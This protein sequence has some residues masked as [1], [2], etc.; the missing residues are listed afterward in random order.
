MPEIEESLW[1][2]DFKLPDEKVKTKKIKEK[3]SKPKTTE[4]SIEKQV[5]SKKVSIKEKMILIK[6]EVLRV[7]GKQAD[8]VMCIRDKETLND[9]ISKAIKVGRIAIDTETNNTTDTHTCKLMGPCLYTPGEKQV[10]IPINHRDPETKE[11]LPNQLTEQDMHDAFQRIVDAGTHIIMHHADFDYQVIHYT[12]GIDLPVFWDTMLAAQVLNENEP[13]SLKEQYIAKIDPDQ[14]KYKIN[15]LFEGV[16]YA[17]VDPDVFAF[18]AATD[19]K[20]TDALYEWQVNEFAKPDNVKLYRVFRDVEMAVMP[21]VAKMEMRGVAVDEEYNR[22][23]SEKYN[24][25]LTVCDAAIAEELEK[26]KPMINAWRLSK[27][28]NEASRAYAPKKSKKKDDEIAAQ[29]PFVDEKG[30]RYKVGKALVEQ[31]PEE[32]NL[33]SPVQLAILL[34]NILKAPVVDKK[35]PRATGEDALEALA[36]KTQLP[37]CNLLIERRGLVKLLSTYIDNIP[38][39]VNFW[40]DRHVHTHFRQ[41][42]AKTG[43]FSSGGK[44]R[45]MDDEGRNCEISSVNM[46]NIPAGQKELRMQFKAPEGMRL[47]GSDFSAQEVR[48]T[49]F[50]TQDQNMIQAYKDGKDLYAVVASNMYD[51]DYSDNREFYE[52]GTEITFEG[53]N[54]ICGTGKSEAMQVSGQT[55]TVPYYKMLRTSADWVM[56]KDLHVGDALQ[57]DD[58]APQIIKSLST[59]GK[60]T[61]IT[62]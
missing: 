22:R 9:Y 28:A 56:A 29:Y 2:D 26:L 11:K 53:R 51:N 21:V 46:Q 42:G 37:I 49:A 36:E 54:V 17:D 40:P 30:M 12:C 18:Y 3:L 44:V 20:M 43:R 52:E 27:E 41:Y 10:Y 48:M 55:F 4:A 14:E 59:V 5:K 7:L 62:F 47:V 23:L 58:G 32:I 45:Y 34:Y 1:G 35:Q 57:P 8:N 31:L 33:G 19:S 25:K 16:H 15:D 38:V 60:Q 24:N 39:L 13:A 6:A 61:T 50:M